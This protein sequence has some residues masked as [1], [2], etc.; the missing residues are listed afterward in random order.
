MKAAS[1]LILI[2]IFVVINSCKRDEKKEVLISFESKRNDMVSKQIEDRG[3]IDNA[4]LNSLRKVERHLFVPKDQV[5]FAYDDNPLPIGYGQTISQPY[6][7]GYMTELIKPEKSFKVLEIGTGSGYQAAVLAEIVDSVFTIE[8]IPEL[9]SSAMERLEQLGYK[10]VKVKI[11]DGYYGT[12]ESAPFDAI[13]VTAA[14]E[15]IPPPLLTQLKDGGRMVIPI[16]SP[17]MVQMLMLIEKK[18][19]EITTE[20]MLPVRFV[21]FRRSD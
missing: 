15:Y 3:V 2:F 1:L 17:F 7:V 4:T 14:S 9:G 8:I 16:G 18:D 5:N 21:P 19:G 13:I 11:G 12:V 10:N 20:N 6:I